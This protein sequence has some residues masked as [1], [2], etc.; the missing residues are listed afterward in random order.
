MNWRD[1]EAA[2]PELVRLGKAR[3]DDARVALLGTLRRDGSPRI[4]PV[5]PYLVG[6][7]L[8]FGAMLWSLKA[9][10]LARDPRCVLHSAVSAPDAA[11][12]ELRLYGRAVEVRER[13]LRDARRDAWWTAHRAEAARVYSLEIEQ[14]TF[15][16]WD[17]RRGEMTVR[18]WS[19]ERGSTERTRSY[20]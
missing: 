7:E 12:G 10:D 17:L 11:E 19:P 14:A 1:L 2:A 8:L 9:R 20:P 18:R 5:E 15:I 16:S 6:G 4:S 13:E 3:L